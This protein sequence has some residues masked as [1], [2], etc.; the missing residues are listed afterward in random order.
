MSNLLNSTLSVI[1]VGLSHFADSLDAQG[2]PTA[3]VK[4]S[5]PAGGD[6]VLARFLRSGLQSIAQKVEEANARAFKHIINAEPY[7]VGIKR[8]RDVVPGMEPNVILHSGPPIS[9]DRMAPVQQKGIL[10]A[11]Q[12][13]KLAEDEA[14]ALRLVESGAISVRSAMDM[15]VAG[16]G[17]GI[18]SPSM[19]VNVC[20]ERN[21]GKEAYCVP[22]EGRVGLG[23]WGVYNPEVEATL[24][25]I[26]TV[27]GPAIDK[28]LAASDGIP[29]RNI[30]AQGLQMND[31]THTRQTAEGYI[32]V[33]E[34]VPLLLQADLSNAILQECVD[35][36]VSSER[37]FHPLGIAS[38]LSVLKGIKG[39][40]YCTLLCTMCGNAVDYGIQVSCLG[41][42]WFTSPSPYLTGMYLSP[43][44]SQKDA[45][46]WMGDSCIVEAY[47]LGAFSGAA[48]PAVIRLRGGS[49]QDGIQ[50]SEEMKQITTGVNYN[51]PI[52]LL[53]FSG[54]PTGID[55]LKVGMT[56]IT[57]LAHGG[58]ISHQ[59][60]QIGAGVVRLPFECF[61]DAIHGVSE[62]YGLQA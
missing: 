46:P 41:D 2:I 21:T 5:P 55:I 12:H 43:K 57:P 33:S 8:A 42:R 25:R 15:G 44:W 36:F 40:E 11:V 7:W 51:Y 22:F 47:G 54:P 24:H 39:M 31:D 10:G 30:I 29:V 6:P 45:V 58:I 19:V 26:E 48:A 52:P 9:W 38:A 62:R 23:V 61:R 34:I 53:G 18:V 56:G 49:Y 32:L 4:W 28:A 16:A 35:L 13:E 60:G 14:G 37:W 20:R 17:A 1:N 27:L 59:G 50:Q 3:R